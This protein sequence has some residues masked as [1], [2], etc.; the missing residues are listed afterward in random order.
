MEIIYNRKPI[1]GH[2]LT[3]EET[4]LVPVVS[5]KGLDSNKKYILIMN[6]PNAVGGNRIHWIV[7]DINGNYFSSGK[8][9]LFYR[10]PA[11]PKNSGIHNYIFSL[12]EMTHDVHLLFGETNRKINMDDLL[13]KFDIKDKPIYTN[14][15]I[16]QNSQEDVPLQ[17]LYDWFKTYMK[18]I[19]INILVMLMIV[20]I[21]I[22][23]IL[24]VFLCL[25]RNG[26]ST[27]KLRKNN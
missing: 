21:V 9:L 11:P 6:D 23:I 27:G 10:G 26:T 25:K 4:A 3:T 19:G 5:L 20:T 8:N 13:A 17:K 15:F 12:Y 18:Y 2:F 22:I 14:R 7:S 16:S 24:Y 1:S